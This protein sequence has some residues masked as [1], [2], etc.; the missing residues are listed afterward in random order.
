MTTQPMP[1]PP[2]ASCCDPVC[3]DPG[4]GNASLSAG[5]TDRRCGITTELHIARCGDCDTLLIRQAVTVDL[6]P[7]ANRAILED[8]IVT[9]EGDWQQVRDLAALLD[10]PNWLPETR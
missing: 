7:E 1:A 5:T 4:D 3:A 6:A 9:F 10:P 2:A 8:E